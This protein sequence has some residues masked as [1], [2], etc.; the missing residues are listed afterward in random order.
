MTKAQKK[1]EPA[2]PSADEVLRRLLNTPPAPFT[3]KPKKQAQK[4]AK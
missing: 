2:Q 3:P 4:Q 1:P